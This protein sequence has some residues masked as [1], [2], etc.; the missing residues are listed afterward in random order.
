V[1]VAVE[2]SG[3]SKRYG[4]TWALRDCTF[5]LP[6][7]RVSAL[8]G[9]NGAGKTTLLHLAT[10]LLEP[11]SGSIRV[12]GDAPAAGR[13]LLDL[14]GNRGRDIP[15][16]R[17]SADR[18]RGLARKACELIDKEGCTV[19][20]ATAAACRVN[21]S[22]GTFGARLRPGSFPVRPACAIA[23]GASPA[24]RRWCRP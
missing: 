9:P 19:G 24:G 13:A 12:L 10:G 1:T 11:T 17:S 8:V 21:P 20:P 23:P 6:L 15:G 2:V 16:P 22:P 18:V 7:G 5:T 4:K 14:S 3:L